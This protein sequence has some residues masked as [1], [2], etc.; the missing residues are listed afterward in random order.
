MAE[1]KFRG[2]NR[3]SQL[4]QG[5]S[6]RMKG[7]VCANPNCKRQDP[8]QYCNAASGLAFQSILCPCQ[9]YQR[10]HGK[11]RPAKW[12]QMRIA[13]AEHP[14][15]ADGICE[16]RTRDKA[17]KTAYVS[18]CKNSCSKA[19]ASRRPQEARRLEQR[20]RGSNS[21]AQR[22]WMRE[23]KAKCLRSGKSSGPAGNAIH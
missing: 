15:P 9:N 13:R 22:R 2:L 7:R 23:E 14:R 8:K 11:P 6:E 18:W 21:V 3:A 10:I 16:I 4:L 17:G 1:K 5:L 20:R 12:E 19:A